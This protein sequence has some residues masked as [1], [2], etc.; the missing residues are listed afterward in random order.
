MRQR[1]PRKF[2]RKGH[3]RRRKKSRK[4]TKGEKRF[5]LYFATTSENKFREVR[6]ILGKEVLRKI[7]LRRANLEIDEFQLW[8]IRDVAARKVKQAYTRLKKPVFV[9]DTALFINSL[10]RFPGPFIS[11]IQKTIG[12]Q[13]LLKLLEDKEFRFAQARSVIVYYDGK[14]LQTF[15]GAVKGKIA[16]KERGAGWG[17]DPIFIPTDHKQTYA[18]MGERK[19]NEVSHRR[20]AT[21]KF[22]KWLQ[23]KMK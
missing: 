3:R 9:E 8:D 16:E 13:G 5:E 20:R 21:E 17:F 14:E 15:V 4:R 22:K 11:W 18:E 19:K 6:R 2:G 1:R 23:T 10:N 7:Q 12:N